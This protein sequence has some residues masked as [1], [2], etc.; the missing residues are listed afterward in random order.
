[1]IEAPTQ[2]ALIERMVEARRRLE[3]VA[4]R[5]PVATSA[6]LDQRVSAQ[7]FLK[8]ENLQRM[9][10]FKFRGA[11][12]FLSRLSE[13]ERKRG[14]VAFSS[15]NHG[16]AVALVA[17]LFGAPATIVM[18]SFAPRPKLDATREY[19]AEV[20]FYDQ[21][22][23]DRQGMAERLARERDR[24]LVPPFDHPD[25]VTGQGTA[26]WELIEETGPLDLLLVPVGGGG[27][28]SGSAL[29]AKHLLPDC[30]V[31]GVEPRAGDD[32]VRSFKA[33]RLMKVENPDTIADGAR[34][35]SLGNLTFEL[36]RRAV[37]DMVSV[38]DVELKRAMRF[39]WE[40]MKLIVEPT[41]VLGLAALMSGAVEARG[42][43]VG[44]IVSGGNVD[45]AQAV[46]WFAEV[47]PI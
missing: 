25:I 29:A 27:L 31:V 10:A 8:C 42:K 28:L 17:R 2:D 30:R 44:V 11:Y 23:E 39:V 34:T 24:T 3:G 46:R 12:H 1:M 26:A 9:G 16:Q 4:H 22:G 32:G 37:D 21:A 47:G 6:T 43:R 36:I 33:G 13:A 41:G 20:V 15:G 18:P 40:R 14:V 5:T 7:V 45:P 38:E 35:P 19:G